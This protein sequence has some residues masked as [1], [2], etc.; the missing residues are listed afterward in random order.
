MENQQGPKTMLTSY[1]PIYANSLFTS[2]LLTYKT[3]VLLRQKEIYRYGSKDSWHGLSPYH[4]HPPSTLST[5][6]PF[7]QAATSRK[8]RNSFSS[9]PPSLKNIH[10][11]G[12]FCIGMVGRGL[13]TAS[14]YGEYSLLLSSAL[15]FV[16][17]QHV[18]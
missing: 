14:D 2:H 6:I 9:P 12:T 1:C 3:V 5:N 7:P 16:F 8:G 17:C 10:Y 11:G 13:A 4:H 15:F 18:I